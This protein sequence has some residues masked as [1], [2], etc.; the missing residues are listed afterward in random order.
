MLLITKVHVLSAQ[1]NWKLI[2]QNLCVMFFAAYIFVKLATL[3]KHRNTFLYW[4]QMLKT[5][6]NFQKTSITV[7][8]YRGMEQKTKWNKQLSWPIQQICLIHI[9]FCLCMKFEICFL[10]HAPFLVLYLKQHFS[11]KQQSYVPKA[12]GWGVLSWNLTYRENW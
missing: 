10:R 9:F 12:D 11:T 6:D 4:A 3:K 5:V 7:L 8:S 1:L 2:E